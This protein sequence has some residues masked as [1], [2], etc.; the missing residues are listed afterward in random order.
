MNIIQKRTM[1]PKQSF[2]KFATR[3]LQADKVLSTTPLQLIQN[4][5]QLYAMVVEKDLQEQDW[6]KL[7][8]SIR[9][10]VLEIV[11]SVVLRW[12]IQLIRF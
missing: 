1:N 11:D 10:H 12:P 3:H 6:E 8:K 7:W 4:Y 9:K 2:V 5:I